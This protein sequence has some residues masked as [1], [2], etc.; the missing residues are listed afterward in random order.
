ME[1]VVKGIS[2][3]EKVAIAGSNNPIRISKD[4]LEA[5]LMAKSTTQTISQKRKSR[6]ISTEGSSPQAAIN[7]FFVA[8]APDMPSGKDIISN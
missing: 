6:E 4:V 7:N 3:V 2:I 8:S 5:T 1:N